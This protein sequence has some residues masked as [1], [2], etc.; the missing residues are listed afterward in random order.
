[1]EPVYMPFPKKKKRN[2][3]PGMNFGDCLLEYNS[4]AESCVTMRSKPRSASFY[5]SISFLLFT[6]LRVPRIFSITD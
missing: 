1:M 5:I 2:L 4:A 6:L 3:S